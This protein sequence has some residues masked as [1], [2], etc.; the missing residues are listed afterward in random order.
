MENNL[1]KLREKNGLTQK[2]VAGA[3]CTT[4]QTVI[5]HETGRISFD[6]LKERY[7]KLY[8]CRIQDLYAIGVE[9]NYSIDYAILQK[10]VD[11]IE[12]T[13]RVNKMNLTKQEVLEKA[14]KLYD[15]AMKHKSDGGLV[16]ISPALAELI[17]N[18]R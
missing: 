14:S 2:Q 11:A 18:Q 15:I 17:I 7:A 3:I 10:A 12:I 5:R 9:N 16:E 4:E 1:K 13:I 8:N 6:R